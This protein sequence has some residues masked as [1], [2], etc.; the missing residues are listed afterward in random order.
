MQYGI[1]FAVNCR[2]QSAFEL[3]IKTDKFSRKFNLAIVSLN[4]VSAFHKFHHPWIKFTG[5][6]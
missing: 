3:E 6:S 1:F 2:R 5:I 4:S